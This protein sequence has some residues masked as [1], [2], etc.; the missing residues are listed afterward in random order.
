MMTFKLSKLLFFIPFTLAVSGGL[1][2][3]VLAEDKVLEEVVVSAYRQV[4]ALDM[5]TSITVLN[6][7]TIREASVANFE[8][9]VPLVPNMN[10]S[11]EG[12]RARYFQLRGVG[13]REQYEGAPNPSVGYY[14][15][16]AHWQEWFI[17]AAQTRQQRPALTPN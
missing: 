6:E 4:A 8:E 11:G 13:E 16:P 9:L 1:T 15:E 12:S 3:T 14:I 7:A 5:D 17:C 10:F 2:P